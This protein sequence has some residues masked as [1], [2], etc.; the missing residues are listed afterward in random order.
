VSGF[1]AL[2]AQVMSEFDA[3]EARMN[4]RFDALGAKM[5]ADFDALYAEMTLDEQMDELQ[6]KFNGLQK[7]IDELNKKREGEV[8]QMN[9]RIQTLEKFLNNGRK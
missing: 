9:A 2:N 8:S 6:I 1:E 7:R 3:S 5:K 4:S